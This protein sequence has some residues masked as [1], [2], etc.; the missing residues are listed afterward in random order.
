MNKKF[1][2]VGH[3]LNFVLTEC[4]DMKY[5]SDMYPFH[6]D[7]QTQGY[8]TNK[9]EIYKCFNLERIYYAY[10][11]L[12]EQFQI[13][14]S[15]LNL[16]D[17]ELE[18]EDFSGGYLQQMK[19]DILYLGGN[20][21]KTIPKFHEDLE[22]LMIDEDVDFESYPEFKPGFNYSEYKMNLITNPSKHW[23]YLKIGSIG[24]TPTIIQR[25]NT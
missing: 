24:S 18:D 8:E 22:T 4:G 1:I 10:V 7:Q 2:K 12:I 20:R 25:S 19:L 15:S 9:L 21:L 14:I 13:R 6:L 16:E 5:Y 3:L 23:D 11:L 17:L